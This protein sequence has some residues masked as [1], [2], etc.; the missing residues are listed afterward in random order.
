MSNPEDEPEATQEQID[1]HEMLKERDRIAGLTRDQMLEE[2]ATGWAEMTRDDHD[3]DTIFEM[4]M[5]GSVGAVHRSTWYLRD[6]MYEVLD[7]PREERRFQEGER[8]DAEREAMTAGDLIVKLMADIASTGDG[9]SAAT[10]GDCSQWTVMM[11]HDLDGD[12]VIGARIVAIKRDSF[13][14]HINLIGPK[15]ETD[16]A[17]ESETKPKAE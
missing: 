7:I 9:I 16:E 1:R 3:F 14:R 10:V 4:M 12:V 15:E 8:P 17:I 5:W 11:R 6:D 13:H 2:T